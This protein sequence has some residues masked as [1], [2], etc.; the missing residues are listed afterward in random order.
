MEPGNPHYGVGKPFIICKLSTNRTTPAVARFSRVHRRADLAFAA[1]LPRRPRTAPDRRSP[2]LQVHSLLALPVT[3]RLRPPFPF[4]RPN[5]STL[6]SLTLPFPS[7]RHGLLFSPPFM[8][9]LRPW[10]LP[11]GLL[12]CGAVNDE[13]S[14]FSCIQFLSVPGVYD[15]VGSQLGLAIAPSPVWPS[16][17]IHKV[18]IPDS[19]FRSSIPCPLMPRAYA[20]TTA[21]RPP[22]QDSRSGGSLL[23][24]C[25]TLSFP[26]ACRFIPALGYPAM[27][28]SSLPRPGN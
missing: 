25:R 8:R 15:Y 3:R 11:A 1:L 12:P 10:P 22:P 20:A 7:A 6:P 19:P 13:V 21:S 5:P 18:G 28:P 24:S 16:P 23:L 4:R 17:C 27:A 14:R 9:A 2:S 26:T